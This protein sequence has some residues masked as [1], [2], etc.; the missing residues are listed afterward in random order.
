MSTAREDLGEGRRMPQ[1]V[2]PPE[3][4]IVPT[5]LV[6]LPPPA[7]REALGLVGYLRSLLRHKVLIVATTLIVTALATAAAF[8]LTPRYKVDVLLSHVDN[9]S[10]TNNALSAL[11]GQFTTLMSVTGVGL[12]TDSSSEEAVALL[13]SREFI[14]EFITDEQ[15]I[16]VLFADKWDPAQKAWKVEGDDVPTLW[17][18]VKLFNDKIWEVTEDATTGLVTASVEWSDAAEAVRWANELVARANVNL[19]TR[20]IDEAQKSIDYLNQESSKTSIVNAQQAV[21]GLIEAQINRKMLASVQEEYAFKVVDPPFA[22]DPDAFTFPNRPLFIAAGVCLGLFFGVF[23]ALFVDFVRSA[24][25][26]EAGPR[27]VVA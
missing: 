9:E 16:P 26:A 10:Q 14:G 12:P 13:K 21:Y 15:L 11:A 25:A 2:T 6:A 8:I 5:Y 1:K 3:E 23:L 20:A 7:E 18:A 19:R 17:D 27:G 22:P 4:G 24:R